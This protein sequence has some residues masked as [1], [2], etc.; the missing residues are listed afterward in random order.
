MFNIILKYA[1][2]QAQSITEWLRYVNM[3]ELRTSIYKTRFLM[4]PFCYSPFVNLC[5]Q[6]LH[7]VPLQDLLKCKTDYSR[8]QQIYY[9][10]MSYRS[11]FD[12]AYVTKEYGHIFTKG[13]TPDYILNVTRANPMQSLP[14]DRPWKS[15]ENHHPVRIVHHDALEL[16][17]DLSKFSIEFKGQ[18]AS[19]LVCSID[20]VLLI[21]KY[22][23][24]V[25]YSQDTDDDTTIET[26]LQ[27]HIIPVWFDDLRTI[28][29]FN[30][31][32]V[33][34]FGKYDPAALTVDETIAPISSLTGALPDVHRIQAEAQQKTLLTGEFLATEWFGP[35]YPIVKWIA[36]MRDTLQVPNLRQYFFL[37]FLEE[38]PYA[39]FVIRLNNLIRSRDSE[40][41]NRELYQQ[42]KRYN[43][44][45]VYTSI[46]Q[47]QLR[48]K[49]ATEV[50]QLLS[51]TKEYQTY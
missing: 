38:F 3:I 31:L 17:T 48:E 43:D 32:N 46:V 19:R 30:I 2:G 39:S 37:K 23:K 16:V 51:M 8:Y 9:L 50:G 14:L 10:A 13:S 26:Y 7:D 35:K 25:E 47:P 34:M 11:I 41:V 49:L 18:P 1:S 29:L 5:K 27:R 20:M 40:R 21:F 44:T 36:E 45:N 4:G 6:I 15:W 33:L 24:F 22:L 28:W 42:L 12:P